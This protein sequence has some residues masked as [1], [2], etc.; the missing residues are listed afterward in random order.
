MRIEWYDVVSKEDIVMWSKTVKESK[1]KV[2]E[3]YYYEYNYTIP[4]EDLD[5]YERGLGYIYDYS[6][7]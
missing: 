5:Y 1:E 2:K 6:L 4:D 7:Y 3:L